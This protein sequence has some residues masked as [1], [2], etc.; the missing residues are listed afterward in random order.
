VELAVDGNVCVERLDD[1][2]GGGA[3][4]LVCGTSSVL[5]PGTHPGKAL[6]EFRRQIAAKLV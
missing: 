6:E 1:L 2:L 4:H 5:R 3:D